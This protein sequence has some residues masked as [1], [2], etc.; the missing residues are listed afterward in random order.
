MHKLENWLASHLF[1][2]ANV[3]GFLAGQVKPFAE[4]MVQGKLAERFFFILYN[5]RGP[6][7]RLRFFSNPENHPVLKEKIREHF[8]AFFQAHPSPDPT[9]NEGYAR[10]SKEGLLPN[11]S[12]QFLPYEP[13]YDRYG[14]PVGM[15]IAEEHFSYSSRLILELMASAS[16]W[17]Y[18]A[19]F[20][21]AV[22]MH[23]SFAFNLGMTR[24][25]II[26]MFSFFGM[27]WTGY[28]FVNRYFV[29]ELTSEQEEKNLEASQ[30]AFAK[31]FGQQ[32]DRMVGMLEMIVDTIEE[33]EEFEQDWLNDWVLHARQ[34]GEK[35]RAAQQAG[36]LTAEKNSLYMPKN[37]DV[38]IDQEVLDL[39]PIY[40]SYVHMNNNRIGVLNRD[41]AFLGYIIFNALILLRQTTD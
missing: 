37:V 27:Q 8:E 32:K 13:E 18:E 35:L 17:S 5:E 9:G 2:N 28:S 39:W 40:L 36:Q 20:A 34:I 10:D 24:D 11:N 26:H 38:E 14:G 33:G 41:E 1:Y 19:A 7:V 31:S 4:A 25:Q 16:Q 22:Q 3:P 6:H 29:P 12:V 21:R 30:R 23:V 15:A